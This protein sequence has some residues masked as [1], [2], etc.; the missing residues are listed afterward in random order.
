[1]ERRTRIFREGGTPGGS[2]VESVVAWECLGVDSEA[3]ESA[4]WRAFDRL[5]PGPSVFRAF[6]EAWPPRSLRG[7][8]GATFT[9][10]AVRLL[11]GVVPPVPPGTTTLG[12]GREAAEGLAIILL[13]EMAAAGGQAIRAE[14]AD[15][16]EFTNAE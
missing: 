15:T 2:G 5:D 6:L 12:N 13:E 7:E 3:A 8:L 14:I 11:V 9:T 10:G 1:M 16:R 4:C